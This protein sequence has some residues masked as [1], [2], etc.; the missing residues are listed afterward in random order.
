MID[1][2]ARL[3]NMVD[4]IHVM[5]DIIQV[6]YYHTNGKIVLQYIIEFKDDTSNF[7]FLL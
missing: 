5:I 2:V 1:G 6:I 3:A 4:T 7:F